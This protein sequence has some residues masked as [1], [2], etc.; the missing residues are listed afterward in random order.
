MDKIKRFIECL[1]PASACNIE[2]NYCYVIQ[3]NQRDVNWRIPFNYTPKVIGEA[4]SLERM[5]GQCY[6]SICGA[7]ETLMQQEVVDI[8]YNLLEQGHFVNIT[9]N[10][11]LTKRFTQIL[12]FPKEYLERLHFAFSFHYLELLPVKLDVFFDNVNRVRTAGCSFVVQLN[13]TDEYLPHLLD[14]KEISVKRTGALPQIVATRKEMDL[15]SN[16]QFFTQHSKEE[17]QKL[18][19][20]FNSPLFDFTMKN[21][22]VKRTAFC[23]AGE[24]SATLNLAT[25][26]MSRCYGSSLHQN[27]FE[28]TQKPI[29]FG[30]VGNNCKTLYCMNAS[31]FMALGTIPSIDTPTYASLRNRESAGWYSERMSSFLNQKLGDNNE[32]YTKLQIIKTKI[33]MVKDHVFSVKS[34]IGR[35]RR[36]V[37][38]PKVPRP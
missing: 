27:I 16:I 30:A 13:L 14:I 37:F 33:D 32:P 3:R 24:W 31:H 11:T 35:Y 20:E 2:C 4:L 29:K 21:F 10:G 1:V 23:Y 34:I 12:Q 17:Y 7:G 19:Q 25:G 26:I 36:K 15:D 8:T 18:G 6:F 9:T 38:V 22:G 28:D 5:G